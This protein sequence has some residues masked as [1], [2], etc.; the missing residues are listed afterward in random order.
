MGRWS[1]AE[2]QQRY[3][4]NLHWLYS[5]N[6][7]VLTSF[8]LRRGPTGWP[9]GSLLT[10]MRM[11][12]AP[13]FLLKPAFSEPNP[14]P[15]AATAGPSSR[16]DFFRYQGPQPQALRKKAGLTCSCSARPCFSRASVSWTRTPRTSRTDAEECCRPSPPEMARGQ[17]GFGDSKCEHR[18]RT[19]FESNQNLLVDRAQVSSCGLAVH[20][21]HA[22]G[23][24]V[25]V[26]AQGRVAGAWLAVGARA[27][28]LRT[29]F[30]LK[31]AAM[32]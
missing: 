9:S 28:S 25:P 11:M 1:S 18:C 12:R 16:L 31:K 15:W 19:W 30:V 14:K 29:S 13:F 23:R 21:R 5:H 17:K 27:R 20:N 22:A 6:Y 10:M 32:F 7:H 8:R 3:E 26:T 4:W 2:G 24:A